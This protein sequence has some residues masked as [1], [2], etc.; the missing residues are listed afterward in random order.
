MPI[1]FSQIPKIYAYTTKEHQTKGWIK[2]GQTIR[3]SV[4]VRIKEQTQTSSPEIDTVIILF[5]TEAITSD[6][7]MFTDHLIHKILTEKGIKRLSGEWFECTVDDLRNVILEIKTGRK[8]D[9]RKTLFDFALR[10]EQQEA[11]EITANYFRENPKSEEN[12]APHFLWNAKMRF[13]KTFTTYKLALEMGWT[14]ILILTYKPVVSSAWKE[15]LENHIDFEGWKFIGKTDTFD[16]IDQSKPFVWFAS[17]QD[18]LGRDKSGN[19][20]ERLEAAHLIE[21]DCVVLDEYHFGSW[22]ESARDLYAGETNKDLEKEF[23]DSE[24]D[25][26]IMPLSVNHF[27]YLSGTP[28]RAVATGE[29]LEDQIYNWT[30]ADEQRAKKNWDDTNTEN[31]YNILPQIMLLTYELPDKVREVAVKSDQDGFSLNEFFKA[32]EIDGIATFH[33]ENQVQQWLNIIRGQDLISSTVAGQE[34]YTPPLPFKDLSLLEHLNHTFW[35]LPSVASCKAMSQLI[36]KKNNT[37]YQDY[38]IIVCAGN[39][40][41]TG[42][43][44][45]ESVKKS[46]GSGLRTKSITLSCG[47]L[48]TGVSV[49]QWTGIFFLRDTSTP[50]TYFQASFRVQTPWYLN[51]IESNSKD[52]LKKICY[53]FDFSPNRALNLISEYN[54]RLN[55]NDT[56]KQEKKVQEF[57]NFLPVLCYDGS[58]M[59]ELNATQLLDIA[60]I[61]VASSMLAKRWQSPQMINVS[62]FVLGKLLENIELLASLENIE[63]FRNLSDNI[64]KVITSEKDIKKL[65]KENLSLKDSELPQEKQDEQKENKGIKKDLKEKLLKFITRVPVF[66]YLTNH[67]EATLKE[68]I[69]DLEPDLFTRVTAL[70][71]RDFRTLCEIGVF[72]SSNLNSAIFAFRRYEEASL[73][74][75]G[76]KTLHD[77]DIV[78][79]WDVELE[80]NESNQVIDGIVA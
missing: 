19:I 30:Y 76:G 51:H 62:D 31:P 72:N 44:A 68:V 60:L 57:L 41:G 13:G 3:K 28:F 4:D 56:T 50:E 25:E 45:F 34:N 9:S 14:K 5:Q 37:F 63:A 48:T 21:W 64:T 29:F 20:K 58:Q 7:K 15:D 40:I 80:R 39:E 70:K 23:G 55:F 69:T 54:T 78:G 52:I 43:K 2:I 46:I 53:V 67:R 27:L 47:K 74:Y 71:L 18:I 6:G 42:E 11:V 10:P 59:V 66:M 8:L 17:F 32:E 1:V 77:H 75:I 33:H 26:E 22:K 35:F 49:P 65:K 61:G 73:I 16:V 12:K 38:T 24:F 36:N 79:G